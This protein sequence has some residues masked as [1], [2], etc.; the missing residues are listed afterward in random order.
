MALVRLVYAGDLPPPGELVKALQESRAA[1][2][3][4][5]PASG[6]G[7]GSRAEARAPRPVA[8]AGGGAMAVAMPE[9]AAVPA[10]LPTSF[11]QMM[12]LV[13][14]ARE[15]ILYADLAGSVHLVRYAPGAIEF[16]PAPN[17]PRDLAARLGKFLLEATGTRWIIGVSSSGGEPT[18]REQAAE[19]RR[20][21]LEAASRHPMVMAILAAFPGARI[22]RV[23]EP[24]A[25]PEAASAAPTEPA[26][27]LYEADDP[28]P[29]AED[30]GDIDDELGDE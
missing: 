4:G 19:H 14:D 3:A 7:G 21:R 30:Y 28:G 5:V 8:F 20:E 1:G 29:G 24:E 26:A 6:P 11:A 17:A 23:G 18:L 10:S 15:G 2:A 22:E 27:T 12:Q 13:A 9:P 25:E 16:R